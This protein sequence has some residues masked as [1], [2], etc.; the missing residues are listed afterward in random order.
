MVA[1]I[2]GIAFPVAVET[3]FPGAGPGETDPVIGF[4]I[5]GEIA[6]HHHVV[7]SATLIPAVKGN[8]FVIVVIVHM[9]HVAV[10]TL[11]GRGCC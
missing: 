5:V 11:A 8:Q 7:A 2:G 3:D 4:R 6:N 9:E 1:K 10:L